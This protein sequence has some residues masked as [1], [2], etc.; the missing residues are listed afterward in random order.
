MWT[1][2]ERI[3]GRPCYQYMRE[4]MVATLWL[5]G[6]NVSLILAVCLMAATFAVAAAWC[7]G[8]ITSVQLQL[9]DTS[10]RTSTCGC[11]CPISCC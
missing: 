1:I 9:V 2:P 11:I 7:P 5:L 4:S 8:L 6:L 10:G 3:C